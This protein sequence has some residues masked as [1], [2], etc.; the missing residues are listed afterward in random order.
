MVQ[1]LFK[2]NF[3]KIIALILLVLFP[4]ELVFADWVDDMIGQFQ[5]VG[6]SYFSGEQRGY[7]G[8]GSFGVR[9]PTKS[10]YLFSIEPPRIQAGCGGIDIYLGSFSYLNPEY[11][12]QKLER[13]LK[14]APAMAFQLALSTLCETCQ[15]IMSELEAIANFFNSLQLD[16]CK[17]SKALVAYTMDKLIPG[18]HEKLT[19]EADRA[20]QTFKDSTGFWQKQSDDY[21][22][23]DYKTQTSPD[24][25]MSSCSSQTKALL[26]FDGYKTFIQYVFAKKGWGSFGSTP[27]WRFASAV[28]GDI[29]ITANN[30]SSSSGKITYLV[31][32]TC[33]DTQGL[34]P[35]GLTN[36]PL[37]RRADNMACTNLGGEQATISKFVERNYSVIKQR[38]LDKLGLSEDQIDFLKVV[39]GPVYRTIINAIM[40]QDYGVELAVQDYI[41]K[42]Y[43]I[44]MIRFAMKEADSA[45]QDIKRSKSRL[46]NPTTCQIED[47]LI[48]LEDALKEFYQELKELQ[49]EPVFQQA[50][51][52]A[53]AQLND[54]LN[55]AQQYVNYE[56]E[57]RDKFITLMLGTDTQ[58]KGGRKR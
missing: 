53:L 55:A 8:F 1:K 51:A 10:D 44:Y 38:V 30:T 33:I 16:E 41:S 28:V 12:V 18:E 37:W 11:L 23:N 47:Q 49:Q 25:R 29:Q 39:P 13:I 58:N 4:V 45:L 52:Q 21:K 6:P 3:K 5:S 31:Q 35:E 43:L 20:I 27:F 2:S 22:A 42:T 36:V 40:A 46:S 14:V 26:T 57:I 48:A 17:A 15:K 24:D 9:Y 19:Q 56:R 54:A 7:V 50:E 32:P 34:T